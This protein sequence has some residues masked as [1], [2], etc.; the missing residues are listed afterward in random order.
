[1]WQASLRVTVRQG[2]TYERPDERGDAGGGEGD[3][4]ASIL[5]ES[6]LARIRCDDADGAPHERADKCAVKRMPQ[7]LRTDPWFRRVALWNY[8]D[9]SGWV[10]GALHPSL[11]EGEFR[12]CGIRSRPAPGVD[13]ERR[14]LLPGGGC[15]G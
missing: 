6:A 9:S 3:A 10:R 1:M 15:M 4:N 5:T 8:V 11:Q 12:R 7:S 2:E 13:A 14:P